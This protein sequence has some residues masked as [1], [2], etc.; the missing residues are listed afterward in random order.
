MH[1]PLLEGAPRNGVETASAVTSL[2]LET[3]GSH[4]RRAASTVSFADNINHWCDPK[5][6]ASEFLADT[7]ATG[8]IRKASSCHSG[9]ASDALTLPGELSVTQLSPHSV[10]TYRTATGLGS[11]TT[12][13]QGLLRGVPLARLLRRFGEHVRLNPDMVEESA[14]VERYFDSEVCKELDQFLSHRWSASGLQKYLALLFHY[15]FVPSLIIAVVA[16]VVLQLCYVH[17]LDGWDSWWYSDTVLMAPYSTHFSIISL[18]VGEIVLYVSVFALPNLLWRGHIFL[19]YLCIDQREESVRRQGAISL[20]DFL[21]KSKSLLVLWDPAYLTRLWTTWEIAAFSSIHHVTCG[22][23]PRT[24]DRWIN[25]LPIMVPSMAFIAHLLIWL[26]YFSVL[27]SW[28]NCSNLGLCTLVACPAMVLPTLFLVAVA[29]QYALDRELFR[30]QVEHFD[31]LKANCKVEADRDLIL[32]SIQSWYGSLEAFNNQLKRTL[33]A[34]CYFIFTSVPPYTTILVLNSASIFFFFDIPPWGFERP[35]QAAWA[36]IAVLWTFVSGPANI[37]AIFKCSAHFLRA[38]PRWTAWQHV[39]VVAFVSIVM[40]DIVV[41]TALLA[42]YLAPTYDMWPTFVVTVM[43]LLHAGY[44][45]YNP[46]LW[47]SCA[48]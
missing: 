34:E 36:C 38:R 48:S 21:Y 18:I 20:P 42:V 44:Q 26:L 5:S 7:A 23:S 17:Y 33:T 3:N 41:G 40:M 24:S 43:H 1:E 13:D 35:L 22:D 39:I 25:I 11:P 47:R 29:R 15:T 32:Q 37:A 31:I 10:G 14:K 12:P 28:R 8:L 2:P 16:V 6:P 9:V 19:D 45:F 30:E 46:Q 4:K 27:L